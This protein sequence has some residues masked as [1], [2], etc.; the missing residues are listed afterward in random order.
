MT[1]TITGR[2]TTTRALIELA[3]GTV[4]QVEV[5]PVGVVTEGLYEKL[6]DELVTALAALA[7]TEALELQHSA[8]IMR[9]LGENSDLKEE[10][11]EA[12]G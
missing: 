6:A 4:E 7:E 8:E 1:A 12:R 9:L 3:D 2:F 10:L 5:E 11:A